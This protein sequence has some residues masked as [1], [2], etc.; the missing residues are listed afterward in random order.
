MKVCATLGRMVKKPS[1]QLRDIIRRSGVTRYRISQETGVSQA[2][3]SKFM[4]RKSSITLD[5][6]DQ[7]ADLLG[8]EFVARSAGRKD[9]RS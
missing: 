8:I 9:R 1:D 5:R 3:L 2:S 6:V 7:L 4:A